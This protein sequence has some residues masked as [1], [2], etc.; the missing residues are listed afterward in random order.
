MS[1]RKKPR[2][3]ILIPGGEIGYDVLSHHLFF[4][5]SS[6]FY[7]IRNKNHKPKE[8]EVHL[9]SSLKKSRRIP[10]R[11]VYRM[12]QGI[13]FQKTLEYHEN[14]LRQLFQ[15]NYQPKMSQ[16]NDV[17]KDWASDLSESTLNKLRV[18]LSW[19]M[20]MNTFEWNHQNLGQQT[21]RELQKRGSLESLLVEG[22]SS[23]DYDY[24]LS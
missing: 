23:L 16:S 4:H 6:L 12:D 13:L 18:H 17:N 19:V 5:F 24:I 3:V 8:E 15:Q 1:R 7:F 2:G 9:M 22:S 14:Q 21:V 20:G 11:I 10:S